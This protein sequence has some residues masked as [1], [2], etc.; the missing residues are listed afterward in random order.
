VTNAHTAL[1]WLDAE[2]LDLDKTRMAAERIVR[3]GQRASDVIGRIRGMMTK[4]T[5]Q[6]AKVDINGVI[7]EVLALTE[8]ELRMHSVVVFTQLAP[9]LA[10]VS[11]DRV[12]LQQVIL[13]LVLNAIDAMASVSDRPR[14]LRIGSQ[15]RTGGEVLISVRDS[16]PG[17]DPE[18]TEKIF[19]PF[20]T[21]KEKGI[22]M[23][24][25]ICRS[26]VEA[27]G[28]RLWTEPGT[29]HG[30]IFQFTMPPEA[31]GRV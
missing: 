8:T 30:A 10:P 9:K 11:G 1:H 28:G 16:G 2:H 15:L 12:Q 31:S 25:S 29:P 17:L 4:S 20:F 24:L 3:D 22:G 19:S 7:D 5:P 14:V 6:V 13:N 26:I 18:T 27:H 23:G 21:T